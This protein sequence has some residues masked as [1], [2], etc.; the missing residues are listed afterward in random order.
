MARR[1]EH[2]AHPRQALSPHDPGQD[3][4]LAS[5]IE[6]S[7]PA[8][9]LLPAWR[10]RTR[11][12][13]LR[14]PLQSSPLPR[15][16]RQPHACRRLLRTR[17]AHSGHQKGDQAP[18]HRSTSTPALQSRSLNPTNEPS[19]LLVHTL[20][21]PEKPDDGQSTNSVILIENDGLAAAVLDHALSDGNTTPCANGSKSAASR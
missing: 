9:E 7:T 19:Y 6:K 3:R 10:S 17:T 1:P 11:H 16:P 13:R 4:T 21:C 8:R 15:E 18:H 5:L 14:R 20:T 12:R 2:A